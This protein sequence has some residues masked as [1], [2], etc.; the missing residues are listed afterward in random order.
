M[1]IVFI[2][3][4][5]PTGHYTENLLKALHN[6]TKNQYITYTDRDTNNLGVKG[7]GIIKPVWRKNIFFWIDILK[8][9][10]IDKP[11]IVHLQHELTMYGSIVTALLFPLLVFILR[12]LG[13]R[14][15]TTLHAVVAKEQITDEFISN[16]M[17][18]KPFYITPWTLCLVFSYIYTTVGKYSH[19]C[20]CHTHRLAQFLHKDYGVKK[21][22]IITI[23]P[24]IPVHTILD[25]KKEKCFLYF[26]YM[27]RR[28][29]IEYILRAFQK[30]IQTYPEYKLILA[31]GVIQ[32][33]E[34]A[35]EELKTLVYSMGIDQA[36]IF[37]GFIPEETYLDELY[38][39]AYAVVIPA[40]LSIAASG[41]LYH[42]RGYHKCILASDIGNFREEI[43]NMENGILVDNEHW[44]EMMRKTIKQPDLVKKLE[45][46]AKKIA[47]Q[48]GGEHIAKQYDR[49]YTHLH[50]T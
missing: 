41:P 45:N 9:L 13:Y 43:T 4:L 1:K 28:K 17:M 39:K 32:G 18:N 12:L 16:F 46:G 34:H 7:C 38:A 40:R 48:N 25:D 50:R 5:L 33:Q 21:D 15:I 11:D 31:G 23:P 14:V 3:S 24:V 30:L 36:V 19:I 27:V 26:G 6:H 2:S 49:L 35:F 44:Y 10:R 8:Q 42:A 29:G 22:K 37:K 47:F 20:I